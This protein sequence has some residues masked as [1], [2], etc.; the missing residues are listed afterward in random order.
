MVRPDWGSDVATGS[1]GTNGFLFCDLRGVAAA[2]DRTVT[3]LDASTGVSFATVG[4]GGAS[5]DPITAMSA[6]ADALHVLDGDLGLLTTVDLDTAAVLGHDKLLGEDEGLISAD[7]FARVQD[8]FTPLQLSSW[9]TDARQ[10]CA[11]IAEDQGPVWA[12]NR[13]TGQLV[14]VAPDGSVHGA[15]VSAG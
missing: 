13:R 5:A 3:A 1:A 11:G 7:D 2:G 14:A 6:G 15:E 12:S 9:A 10:E 4:V 8:T